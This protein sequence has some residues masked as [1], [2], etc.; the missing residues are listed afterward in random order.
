M[1]RITFVKES[2]ADLIYELV[3]NYAR[4]H[5]DALD[6]WVSSEDGVIHGAVSIQRGEDNSV[7]AYVYQNEP[8]TDSDKESV[9]RQIE[10]S[11]WEEDEEEDN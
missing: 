9:T 3:L 5:P 7:V 11:V 2:L 10:A 4:E 6:G 8:L 1:Q